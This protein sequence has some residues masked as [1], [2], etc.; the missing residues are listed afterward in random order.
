MAR[1]RRLRLTLPLPEMEKTPPA[2]GL[3][4][5]DH[6]GVFLRRGEDDRP[7]CADGRGHV[8]EC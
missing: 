5:R 2:P 3:E 6:R 1:V 4:A 7:R 8:G